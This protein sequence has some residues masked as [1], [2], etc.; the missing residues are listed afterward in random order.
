MLDQILSVEVTEKLTRSKQL[1]ANLRTVFTRGQVSLKRDNSRTAGEKLLAGRVLM[2]DS[3]IYRILEFPHMWIFTRLFRWGP[4]ESSKGFDLTHHR[5]IWLPTV[6]SSEES[7]L[8]AH[9]AAERF[10]SRCIRKLEDFCKNH[11]FDSPPRFAV[12]RYDLRLQRTAVKFDSTVH[13][14]AVRSDSPLQNAAGR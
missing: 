5:Q 2:D 1:L 10:D 4:R 7:W 6:L 3:H 12:E 14:A 8:P 11:W 9:Y 13:H